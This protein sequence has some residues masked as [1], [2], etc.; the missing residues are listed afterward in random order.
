MP[1]KPL[2][3]YTKEELQG[4]CDRSSVA[5]EKGATTQ[6]LVDLLK[7]HN[8]A[9][10]EPVEQQAPTAQGGELP[11]ITMAE[12]KAAMDEVKA[13]KAELKEK[14]QEQP[15][16]VPQAG[17]TLSKADMVQMFAQ[18][19]KSANEGET[20]ALGVMRE[21]FVDPTDILEKPARFWCR[22][23]GYHM[24]ELMIGP[25]P[26]A[27]PYNRKTVDFINPMGPFAV[28]DKNFPIPQV[29]VISTFETSIKSLAELLRKDVR[30]GTR[31][32]EDSSVLYGIPKLDEEQAAYERHLTMLNAQH[33][34]M[35]PFA[36][37][38][39]LGIHY[40]AN[41]NAEGLRITLAKKMAA[42]EIAAMN[43]SL[44]QNQANRE[45]ELSLVAAAVP[46]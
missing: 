37:A 2:S 23:I 14:L 15:K 35:F 6:Q 12:L 22:S 9:S 21:Q 42:N 39:E 1:R 25:V 29:W 16:L 24:H 11:T 7:A 38:K 13:M 32:T 34:P 31:F 28:K 19:M 43:A 33:D 17:E 41:S 26:Q 8:K 46:A 40:T 36:K 44:A 20:N 18:A 4:L 30:Y 5:Y 27:F 10:K 45:R 3:E